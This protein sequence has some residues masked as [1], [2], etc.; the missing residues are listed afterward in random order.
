MKNFCASKTSK[1]N[2]KTSYMLKNKCGKLITNK[3]LVSRM[4][5]VSI[6]YNLKNIEQKLQVAYHDL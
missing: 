1:Q 6:E 2:E 3:E 4:Y 5:K